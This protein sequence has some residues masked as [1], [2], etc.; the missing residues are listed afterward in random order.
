MTTTRT[1]TFCRTPL[2]KGDCRF[3][4]LALQVATTLL[5]S[6]TSDPEE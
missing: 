3:V 2:L 6:R 4:K 5:C 1:R